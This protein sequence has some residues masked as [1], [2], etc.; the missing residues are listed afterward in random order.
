MKREFRSG[1][2]KLQVS[3]LAFSEIPHQ[4]LLFTQY[5]QDPLS[6]KSFYPN[7]IESPT[8]VRSFVP[9]VLAN[10][11][12][13]RAQLCDAL[14]E[15]N[16]NAGAGEQTFENIKLLRD[17]DTVAVVTG[18]QAGL[19]TGPIYTIYK[20]LSAVKMAETL[21]ASG[22]K[23]VPVFWAATEDHDFD[24]VSAAS[25]IDRSGVLSSVSYCPPEYID[26]SPVG[27]AAIGDGIEETIDELFRSLPHTEFTE[28]LRV[29]LANSWTGGTRFG[30]AFLRTL[31]A[32][33]DK[34]GMVFLDPMN[35]RLRNLA[36]PI[37]TE[38]VQK[39]DE[40]ATSLINRGTELE[41][42][43]FHSQVHVERDYFPLFLIDETG[44]RVALRKVGDDVYRIKGDKREFSRGELNELASNQ[45]TRLSPG[46][47]LRPV[48]Q[49]YLL[50]T[51]CYFGGGAEIAYFAQNSEV[52]RILNRPATPVF[53]RQS[54]T[55]VEAK[56]RR[57]LEKFGL[58]LIRLF[59]GIEANLLRIAND[60]VG[61]DTARLFDETEEKINIELNR[62]D[63]H[64]S[65]ID[66]TLAD[67][68][69]K[70]RRKIMYHIAAIRKKTLLAKARSDETVNR[71]IKG[72]FAS[73]V[74]NGH[75]QERTINVFT[76]LNKFG[77]N[78]IDW[79]YDAIDLED[80]GHR[81][82]NF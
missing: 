24:E 68:L 65:R 10:Y 2:A 53:H 69:A 55:I 42:Q 35:E 7:A 30:D 49:D 75:L 66:R 74:P 14:A 20:A 39:S 48:V 9:T 57:F 82:V 16:L 61:N 52:Y 18:Q 32:I 56:H 59:D 6:L 79:I 38:A 46:V 41:I 11:R 40:I 12:T 1:N 63:Q 80:K 8:A 19:F 71:Q 73:L 67:N 76:C 23:A 33:L 36:A 21:N 13:D 25:F 45:P 54:F 44:R 17:P 5:Q 27:S 50:P 51:V 72:V 62:L 29:L 31:A 37:Y 60:S 43:G 4:S 3:S 26:G 64:V 34:F 15:T 47:M 28:E 70:R 77:P 81:V 78:F 58:D 22:T